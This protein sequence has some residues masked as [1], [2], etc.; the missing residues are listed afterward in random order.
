MDGGV[1]KEGSTTTAIRGRRCDP[2]GSYLAVEWLGHAPVMSD[3]QGVEGRGEG[4][5]WG[6]GG[7]KGPASG[8]R[9]TACTE[10]D[11]SQGLALVEREEAKQG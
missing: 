2:R 6:G 9:G 1:K 7:A 3:L 5:I 4:S 10:G 8:A 11:E